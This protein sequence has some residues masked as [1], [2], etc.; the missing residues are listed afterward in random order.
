M[1]VLRGL[2]MLGVHPAHAARSERGSAI[3]EFHAL[4]LVL[5]IPLVYVLIAALDVQRATY[6]ATQAA[7]E[8]GRVYVSGGDEQAARIAANVAL[9][10]QGMRP[11]DVDVSLTCAATPC[12][13][14]GAEITV[15]VTASVRLPFLPDMFAD[16]AN[17]TIPVEAVHVG[18][19]DRFLG[20]GSADAGRRV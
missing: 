2:G 6:G 5:L 1:T 8:A 9:T 18:V 16:A 11:A 7:R 13:T 4:G 19:V 12:R 10:D 15:T 14:P 20:A 3:V 17:A